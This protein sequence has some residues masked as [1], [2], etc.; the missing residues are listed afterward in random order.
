M[1]GSALNNVN[2]LSKHSSLLAPA[3][4][5]GHNP[6]IGSLM[7]SALGYAFRSSVMRASELRDS[8]AIWMGSLRLS[9]AF[10]Y[11]AWGYADKIFSPIDSSL[12]VLLLLA[13]ARCRGNRP[14]ESGFDKSSLLKCNAMSKNSDGK[15]TS[16]LAMTWIGSHASSVLFCFS[17]NTFKYN[18]KFCHILIPW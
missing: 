18:C 14:F 3:S 6:V 7:F 4:K 8:A 13:H 2:E 9:A 15:S 10:L 16:D 11:A 12:A 17:A 1:E 5:E